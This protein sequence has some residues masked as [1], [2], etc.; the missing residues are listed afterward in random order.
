M[1]NRSD[2]M[3]ACP[4]PELSA[5]GV[6]PSICPSCLRWLG[7]QGSSTKQ[8]PAAAI[9]LPLGRRIFLV[10]GSSVHTYSSLWDASLVVA[11]VHE[12][13]LGTRYHHMRGQISKAIVYSRA[14]KC[15]EKEQ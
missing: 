2:V 6:T 14:V 15:V 5:P 7:R 12:S 1:L 9:A 3:L 4:N 10:L 11:L 8:A 13:V